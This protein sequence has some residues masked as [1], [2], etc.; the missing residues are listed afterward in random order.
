MAKSV[1][2]LLA[3]LGFSLFEVG[4]G[5]AFLRIKTNADSGHVNSDNLERTLLDEIEGQI[6]NANIRGRLARLE[7]TLHP[8][9]LSLPKNQHGNLDHGTVRYAL[10]RLFVQRHGWYIKGLDNAGQSWNQSSHA[11]ILKDQAADFV[12][13]VFEHRLGDKGLN[14]H[15]LAVL[16]ATLEHLIHDESEERLN[17]AY[18]AARHDTNAS[19]TFEQASEITYAYMKLFILGEEIG[20]TT[21]NNR[22]SQIYP[23]W[24]DTKDFAKA[25]LKDTANE[26]RREGA[27]DPWSNLDFN[28]VSKSVE[29]ISEQYGRFQDGECRAMKND[30]IKLG[31][32]N[33]GRVPLSE[34]YRPA[35]E[36]KSWQFMESVDYLRSLGAL[37]E[38]DPS[39]PSV[40]VPN[41]VGSQSNCVVST[42]YYSVCCIDEC[43]GLTSQL[44]KEFAS[45]EADPK[46]VLSVVA[47]LSS[48]TVT[49]PRDLSA[50]L[51]RRLEDIA[52]G[53]HG[54]VPL[55]GRLFAQWMHHAFP[56]ECP[57]P[58][59]AGTTNP[60]AA[61]EWIEQR[62]T[63]RATKQEMQKVNDAW[64]GAAVQED[65]ELTHWTH[66]EELLVPRAASRNSGSSLWGGVRN[67]MFLSALA[68]VAVRAVSTTGTASTT[69]YG[70]FDGKAGKL[71]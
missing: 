30:L 45:P 39:L 15:E 40:I 55:H 54:S 23:G 62:G 36:G 16:G 10:H 48:S 33:I 49:G 9:F 69:L 34:F 63:A 3:F 64:A 41:Y 7:S 11:E 20:A 56:R 26:Q 61:S 31:D 13:S 24:Q 6:G 43:E 8:M 21:T 1:A 17:K 53:H 4:T 37:D 42:S 71:V 70:G 12:Q 29:E 35:L 32:R 38:T 28:V 57:F 25:I 47:G 50:P 44:E 27:R 14:L 51:I 60:Q 52:E 19:M 18:A 68:A 58:H 2:L 46:E 66:E 65:D 59:V 5:N 22:M 67:I